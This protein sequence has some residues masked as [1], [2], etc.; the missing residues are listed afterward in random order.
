M[1]DLVAAVE[2]SERAMIRTATEGS[3]GLAQLAMMEDPII[4]QRKLAGKLLDTIIDS[5]SEH[6]AYLSATR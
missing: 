6:L 4:G 1:G 3:P 2:T 5:N